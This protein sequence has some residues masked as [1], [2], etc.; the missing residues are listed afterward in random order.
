MLLTD[1]FAMTTTAT[2]TPSTRTTAEHP[3]FHEMVAA[4]RWCQR[5]GV[6]REV[7][8]VNRLRNRRN[9]SN[10]A[11]TAGVLNIART[12]RPATRHT[13]TPRLTAFLMPPVCAILF[14]VATTT[15]A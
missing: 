7:I 10:T 9:T 15:T 8:A 5:G 4:L 2:T 6:Q 13:S 3:F 12:P 11:T 14:L 1:V